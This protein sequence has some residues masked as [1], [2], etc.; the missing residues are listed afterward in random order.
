MSNVCARWTYQG[1]S[2]GAVVF[3]TSS[4]AWSVA[5]YVEERRKFLISMTLSDLLGASWSW[6]NL[7]WHFVLD[8]PLEGR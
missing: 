8:F 2:T 1:P 3:A 6:L 4:C 5:Y 7:T